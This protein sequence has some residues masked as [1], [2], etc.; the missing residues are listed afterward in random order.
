MSIYTD[1]TG[2]DFGNNNQVPNLAV[3]TE[4]LRAGIRDRNQIMTDSLSMA[5]D[6]TVMSGES[7]ISGAGEV[8]ISV[9][10]ACKFSEKPLFYYGG[11]ILDQKTI[12]AGQFPTISAFVCGWSA[13]DVSN[14]PSDPL[15][16]PTSRFYTGAT[17]GVVI[18][19]D[20]TGKYVLHWHFIGEAINGPSGGY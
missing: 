6:R 13:Q 19:G 3:K 7:R 14:D 1:N 16:A 9:P 12:P 17:I 11:E 18:T 20:T 8:L 4:S 2:A 10:F 15:L 5:A